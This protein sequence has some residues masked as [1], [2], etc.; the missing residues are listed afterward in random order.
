[1]GECYVE[2]VIVETEFPVLRVGD[3]GH[4]EVTSQDLRMIHR[5]CDRWLAGRGL[6]IGRGAM[7][8]LNDFEFRS[9]LDEA[10]RKESLA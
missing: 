1:M 5:K 3:G 8:A 7:R 4:S 9:W 2:G 6:P 10:R